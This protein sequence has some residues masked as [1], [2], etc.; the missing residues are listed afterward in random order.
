MSFREHTILGRTGLS[1]SRLGIG[2]GY[3][4][5]SFAVEKAYHEYGVNY[6]FW[7]SPR[8]KGMREAIRNLVRSERDRLVIAIQTYD[9]NGRFMRYFVEKGLRT[10]NIDY[11]DILIL[12]WFNHI[13]KDRVLTTALKLK[14]KGR[15][16]YL[17]MSGHNRSTFGHIARQ[18]D[19]PI[20]I[21][22]VRY[23]AVHRGA[24]TDILPYLP[25][26]GRPGVITY[27]ATCWRKL[28]NQSKMPKGEKSLTSA[29]CYRFVLSNPDVNLC[30]TGPRN[31]KEMD[32]ALLTID[33]SALLPEEIDRIKRIG[34]FI[35][36]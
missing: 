36:G 9:H 20:D 16:R 35:H 32:G 2:S 13:P 10:L 21:F 6:L 27:T 33:S 29:E 24:E 28:L 8:R 12:G 31:H 15:V 5:P 23:N 17:G 3:G 34:D 1:V 7:S 25:K 14:E 19:N 30:L 26:E 4:V 18:P 22:M 11:A